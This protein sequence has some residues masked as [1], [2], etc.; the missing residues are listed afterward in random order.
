MQSNQVGRRVMV[1]TTRLLFLHH[2]VRSI[3][4]PSMLGRLSTYGDQ[5]AYYAHSGASHSTALLGMT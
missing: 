2:G 4:R 1:T 3:S 5:V